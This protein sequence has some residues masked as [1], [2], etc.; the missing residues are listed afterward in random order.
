MRIRGTRFGRTIVVLAVTVALAASACTSVASAPV[1]SGAWVRMP[2][3]PGQP[4]AAYLVLTNGTGRDDTLLSASSPAAG[5]VEIHQTTTSNGMTGM[6][7]VDRVVL[8]AGASLEFA[9]GGMHLMVM[10]VSQPLAVGGKFELDLVFERAGK[11]VI[12]ADVRGN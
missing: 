9:P 3:A 8:P 10:D 11:V 12:Q 7:P 2:A 5:K 1:V 6:Q 4:T